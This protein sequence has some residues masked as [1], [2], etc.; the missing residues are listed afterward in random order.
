MA[1]WRAGSSCNLSDDT[2]NSVAPLATAEPSTMP[3]VSLT[4]P[5]T[6]A[7]TVASWPEA[8]SILP[9]QGMT[10]LNV[11]ACTVSTAMPEALAFSWLITISPAWAC[12]SSSCAAAASSWLWPPWQAAVSSTHKAP[13][14]R[15]FLSI[16]LVVFSFSACK[17][18]AS[19]MQLGCI[20]AE[21]SPHPAA[22]RQA[23][24]LPEA[25]FCGVKG[26]ISQGERRPIV[27]LWLTTGCAVG[28]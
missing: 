6:V 18:K 9:P 12:A 15:V 4:T 10:P 2:V 11:P 19:Q 16:L 1:A 23:F 25:A 14:N 28:R 7:T 20:A 22:R 8:A 17:N 27:T 24:A 26:R 5:G 21:T 3:R 13:V